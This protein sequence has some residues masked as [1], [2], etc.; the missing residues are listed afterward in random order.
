MRTRPSTKVLLRNQNTKELNTRPI[1]NSRATVA[2]R[3]NQIRSA[4]QP[5]CL[6]PATTC[7]EPGSTSV[8]SMSI[9]PRRNG[10]PSGSI[11]PVTGAGGETRGGSV[12]TGMPA[13][14][15]SHTSPTS[16][17]APRGLPTISG[18]GGGPCGNG[19]RLP[20]PDQR[21]TGEDGPEY[22]WLYG[23]STP[24]HGWPGAA[25]RTPSPPG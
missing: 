5:V 24:E 3:P 17:G 23:G 4:I 1:T 6:R 20:M 18:P 13:S 10:E 25:R 14:I 19:Y 15:T 9:T 22:G 7:A 8:I 21:G 2:I 16:D 11:R 12:R